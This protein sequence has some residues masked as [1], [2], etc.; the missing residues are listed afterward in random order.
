MAARGERSTF[1]FEYV[2][3]RCTG[4]KVPFNVLESVMINSRQ[5]DR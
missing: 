2:N 3:I 5:L 4:L 1:L